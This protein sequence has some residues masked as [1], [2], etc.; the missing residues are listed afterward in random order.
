MEFF[1]T[2][3]N[4]LPSDQLVDIEPKD[5]FRRTKEAYNI[6]YAVYASV[7]KLLSMILLLATQHLHS[8][9]LYFSV[10][11]TSL[12]ISSAER[13]MLDLG[14]SILLHVERCLAAS[15]TEYGV[16]RYPLCVYQQT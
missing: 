7:H 14:A 3:Y 2:R 8:Q 15:V 1:Y 13:R 16:G 6:P 5:I 4:L 9:H 11:L 12:P 10:P